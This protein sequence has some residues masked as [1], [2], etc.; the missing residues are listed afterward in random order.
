MQYPVI[1]RV[2]VKISKSGF[3]NC[4]VSVRR[5]L[6]VLLRSLPFTC[7]SVSFVQCNGF[8]IKYGEMPSLLDSN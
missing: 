5:E 7:C 3:D 2:H 1:A 4:K 8:M 6:N